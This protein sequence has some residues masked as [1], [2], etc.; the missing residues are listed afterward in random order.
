MLIFTIA[1]AK[2]AKNV[3]PG[4]A[5][6]VA[7]ASALESVASAE[8]EVKS[9]SLVMT[10]FKYVRSN[11]FGEESMVITVVTSLGGHCFCKLAAN[12]ESMLGS[13]CP[14]TPLKLYNPCALPKVCA[15]DRT[16]KPN[17]SED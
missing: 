11:T 9:P 4:C 14:F 10:Y 5:N 2:S 13:V 17:T 8:S 1:A 7:K 16:D 3:E 6:L 12:V 15:P